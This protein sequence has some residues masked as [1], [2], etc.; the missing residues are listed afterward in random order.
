MTGTCHFARVDIHTVY[1]I[2]IIFSLTQPFK[3]RCPQRWAHKKIIVLKLQNRNI[4][5]D[6]V[7]AMGSILNVQL[8]FLSRAPN[9]LQVKATSCLVLVTK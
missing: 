4:D 6:N 2:F 1:V 7:F 3:T 8:T 5:L 9:V